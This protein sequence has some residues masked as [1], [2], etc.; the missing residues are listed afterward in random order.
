MS[1]KDK[2][3]ML[4]EYDFSGKKGVRG[5]YYKKMQEGHKTII[6]KSD[7]STIVRETR[8]IFLEPEVQ[9]YFPNS[10]A[11]NKALRGLIELVPKKDF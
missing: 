6:H 1:N 3:E 11:V 5:K 9:K 10:E 2:D 7:G 8:P 4:E